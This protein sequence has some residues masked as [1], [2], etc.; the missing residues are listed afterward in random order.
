M[1]LVVF[2]GLVLPRPGVGVAALAGAEHAVGIA[3]G[4][5]DPAALGAGEGEGHRGEELVTTLPV[6]GRQN[7]GGLGVRHRGFQ[8]PADF[9][10]DTGGGGQVTADLEGRL[11]AGGGARPGAPVGP[12]GLRQ[13]QGPA[14]DGQ[15]PRRG[16][17]RGGQGQG[18]GAVIGDAGQDHQFAHRLADEQHPQVGLLGLDFH[19]LFWR[20]VALGVAASAADQEEGGGEDG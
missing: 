19:R 14:I 11:V 15:G 5:F 1:D 16:W 4:R 10:V 20:E 6:A 3:F 7:P 2:R 12:V 17:A 8:A 18:R 9:D 13:G